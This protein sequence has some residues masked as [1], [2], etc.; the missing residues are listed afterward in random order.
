MPAF[1]YKF[2]PILFISLGVSLG[3]AALTACG[4]SGSFKVEPL[5]PQDFVNETCDYL[6]SA[7]IEAVAIQLNNAAS[8]GA[9]TVIGRDWEFRN[10]GSWRPASLSCLW[11]SSNTPGISLTVRAALLP[12]DTSFELSN[13]AALVKGLDDFAEPG[14][15]LLSFGGAD[16]AIRLNGSTN[17]PG[18]AARK[19]N[20]L[21]HIHFNFSPQNENIDEEIRVNSEIRFEDIVAL[22]L[23]ARLDAFLS[24]S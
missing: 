22:Y 17:G 7:E 11:R 3:A 14:L 2:L 16:E 19:Q 4:G 24:Q 6:T 15:R 12:P 13:T 8:S 1:V 5:D 21:F 18:L 23:L 20:L 9:F 10:P